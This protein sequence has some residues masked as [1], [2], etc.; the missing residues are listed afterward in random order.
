MSWE[1][2]D[3]G[4][5][6]GLSLHEL[7]DADRLRGDPFYILA[8]DAL[9][10]GPGEGVLLSEQNPDLLHRGFQLL[11]SRSCNRADSTTGQV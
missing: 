9:H 5:A 11:A 3:D 10:E 7:V 6:A 1:V 4:V 8:A 2:D